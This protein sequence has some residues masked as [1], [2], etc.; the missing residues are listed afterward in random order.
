MKSN[1]KL[2][3]V[4]PLSANK[5]VD[6]NFREQIMHYLK[7][8]YWFALGLLICLT[9]AY[10][11]IRYTIPK[12][13]VSASIM[14]SQDDSMGESELAAFQDLG[15]LENK[16]N[17]IENEIQIIKSRT[18]ITNVVKRLKLNVQ[19]FSQ[20][21]VLETEN[22]PE[23]IIEISLLAP[24][25]IIQSASKVFKVKI[26]SNTK[27]SLLGDG[28]EKLSDH[29]FGNTIKT[30]IGDVVITPNFKEI[31]NKKGETIKIKISPIRWIAESYRNG[32]GIFPVGKNS[33]VV[34]I[35]LNDPVK[36][37]AMDII[38]TLI[39]EYNEATINNKKQTS[40]RTATFINDR[41]DLISGDLTEVDDEAA[42]YKAKFGL[43]N[44]ISAQTQRVA[45]SDTR[46][47][48]EITQ[49]STQLSLIESTRSFILSQEGR[50][51]LV[52]ANLGF[53]DPN[54][55]NTATRYN[56]LI[57]QRNR[58]LTSSSEQNP[59]VININQ[60]IDGL[61]Q[62][63]IESLNSLKGAINIKLNSLKT[64][65]R[66]F[67]GKLYNAPIRQKD[68]RVIE[69][70]QTI[71][72]Q[73]YLYLLQKREEAE[74]TSHV[75]LSNAQIIDRATTIGSYPVSPNKKMIYVGALFM[76]LMIP[77]LIIYVSEL[78]N[79]KVRSRQDLEKVLTM[80]ILGSIPKTKTKDKIV[81]S[82]TNRSGI[83]EAFRI[84]R[85][86]L[87]FLMAGSNK[88]KGKVIFVTSTISGEG[89]TLVSSN[90]A[91]TLTIS[92]KKVAFIGTD[93]RDPKF[94]NFLDLPKGKDTEG[95]TNFIMNKDLSPQDVIYAEKSE[96]PMDILPP[97]VIPPNPA[98]L[99]MQDRVAEMFA[100]LQKH[101][102]YII[103]DTAPVSLV[104]DTLLIGHYSDLSIFIVRENY[105]DKRALQ[106]PENFHREKRLPNMAVLLNASFNQ[107]GYGYGYGYGYGNQDA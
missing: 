95:F 14:I 58:L 30:S 84:L 88:E 53:D 94:H 83:A 4:K 15:L 56:T 3:K 48:Q 5:S 96:D 23:S 38:N 104:T 35:S 54:I 18:L 25:S 43:T 106:V 60:Q 100:Y 102:D 50:Y 31:G 42:G 7:R 78:L 61:R 55:T 32:L 69:R 98:E 52:P 65:D 28:D 49:L 82:R 51:D 41:L 91:K 16:S 33:S 89:K 17:K 20:G 99:L 24:D 67:S 19:Y 107:G 66:Y 44:D 22:Y 37:K 97:G 86:N 47:L 26:V 70:E 45:D 36:E 13:N 87:D 73:L 11:Y 76:G 29:S 85:T 68:L 75:T 39:D 1:S 6:F 59:A 90:L 71:K 72:E 46:N 77:F 27:F 9:L 74:I 63:L 12:Y 101:Y 8:W 2:K 93:F 57:S 10:T 34:Q 62:V 92:G 80:P 40:A 81:V 105:S 103:V 79:V 64:Q 21:R